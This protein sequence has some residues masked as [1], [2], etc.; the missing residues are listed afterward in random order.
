MLACS[1]EDYFSEPNKVLTPDQENLLT[2]LTTRRCKREPLAYILQERYFGNLRIMV[3]P[4]VLIPRQETESLVNLSL[5]WIEKHNHPWRSLRIADVGTGSGCIAISL[6][7]TKFSMQLVATDLSMDAI[8]V[9]KFN[10]INYGL[11]ARIHLVRSD[12]LTTLSGP[13]D[14]IVG[15]LPY[16]ENDAIQNLDPEIKDYEPLIAL[17]GGEQGTDLNLRLLNDATNLLKSG[18]AIILEIDPAQQETLK[19]A[20]RDLFP[21][22]SITILK[23]LGGLDRILKVEIQ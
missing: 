2:K 16:L 13:I 5:L 7:I 17:Q 14:L 1:R 21:N 3:N 18:G 20:A 19:E 4:G 6:A 10:V 11:S 8:K 12:L 22:A 15:N 23:D 9:A